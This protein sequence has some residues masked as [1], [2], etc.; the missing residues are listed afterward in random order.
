MT[1]KSISTQKASLDSEITDIVTASHV[2]FKTGTERPL[3]L[4]R[5]P[6]VMAMTG[7]ARPTVYQKMAAG[8]FPASIDLG[9]RS[10]AWVRSE[11]EGWIEN[12]IRKSRNEAVTPSR[13]LPQSLRER[14][15]N[16]SRFG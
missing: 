2:P 16:G 8:E 12:Q 4:C 14:H 3:S 5:L 11:V 9:L 7:L 10:V 13:K 6:E 15:H 1:M